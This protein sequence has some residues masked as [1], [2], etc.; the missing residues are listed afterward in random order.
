MSYLTTNPGRRAARV[1]R[2]QIVAE[3]VISAY[4]NEITPTQ[5]RRERARIRNSHTDSSP[6]TISRAPLSARTRSRAVRPRHRNALQL[7]SSGSAG[8]W[9]VSPAV[10]L[11]GHGRA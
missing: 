4:I 3:A 10:V 9:L 8:V 11:R 5:H 6:R 2:A 7:A 1:H